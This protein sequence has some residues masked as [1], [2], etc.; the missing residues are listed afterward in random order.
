MPGKEKQLRCYLYLRVSSESQIEGYSLDAQHETLMWAAKEHNMQVVEEFRDEGKSGK[1]TTG[2]P[3]FR[4]MIGRIQNGNP[5]KVDYV[6]VY[7]L[8]RF[9]RNTA[10]VMNNLQIMEDCCVNLIATQDNI[11][12]AATSSKVLIAMLAA[13]AEMERD[14]IHVQTMAGRIQKAREGKWNAGVAPFGYRVEK[15]TDGRNARLVVHEEE[16]AIVRLAFEKYAHTGMGYS[17]V[18]KWLNRNGYRREVRQTRRH[19]TFTDFFV[20]S[21][22]DNPVYTGKIV[23]GRF[24]TE[25]IQGKRNEY[26]AIKRDKYEI[27][28]GIHE[29]IISEALWEEVQAKRKATAN[30]APEHY[31]PK[32][33]HVLSGIVRCPVCDSPM[34]GAV[35]RKKKK[36]GSGGFYSEIYYYVCKNTKIATGKICT[37][38]HS[39]RQDALDEQVTRIVQ[40]AVDNL[41]VRKGLVQA[42]GSSDDL[43]ELT[44]NLKKLQEARKKEARKKTRLL[45]RIAALDADD[46]QYDAMFNDMQG[47][48]RQQNQSISELDDRIEEASIRL[49]NAQ[50]GV[51]TF[52]QVLDILHRLAGSI[53]SWSAEQRRGLMHR[54]LER[55]EIFPEPQQGG[56]LVRNVRFKF[57]LSMDK[58]LDADYQD[59]DDDDAFPP[60]YD[61]GSMPPP[62]G[63]L[64]GGIVLHGFPSDGTEPYDGNAPQPEAP[65]DGGVNDRGGDSTPN[66]NSC[67]E[68]SVTRNVTP[69]RG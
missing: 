64:P 12:S 22:L 13:F 4:E 18:A 41:A 68:E 43:D 47:I 25:K 44:E 63:P 50:A 37:Y 49:R 19:D 30:K 5:D 39:V 40:Q 56:D 23:H 55:V 1:N 14:T 53:E 52:E 45:N 62:K 26:R 46:D 2:R 16:A 65:P 60:D 66:P 57:P 32:H 29:A 35:N 15:D 48:L 3:A 59:D 8:S 61:P 69:F 51:Q 33:V 58:I 54:I 31:G 7:K 17:G 27:Y 11:D 67:P 34:Y 42:F 36:D 21:M 28:D 6:L 38:T 10:D 9:G 20:K 24:G